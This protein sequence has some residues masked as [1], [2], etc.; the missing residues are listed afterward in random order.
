MLDASLC[1]N[2]GGSDKEQL[3]AVAAAIQADAMLEAAKIALEYH[4]FGGVHQGLLRKARELQEG[5]R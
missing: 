3:A 1:L 4:T 2:G 5:A